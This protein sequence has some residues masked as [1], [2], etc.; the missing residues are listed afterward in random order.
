MNP[1]YDNRVA[2][3]SRVGD[4]WTSVVPQEPRQVVRSLARLVEANSANADLQ[5]AYDRMA[6]ANNNSYAF[7]TLSFLPGAVGVIGGDLNLRLRTQ[8]GDG[9][10]TYV[11]YR[12][13]MN[14]G[15]M[16]EKWLSFMTVN[17][18]ANEVLQ[19]EGEEYI[20]SPAFGEVDVGA[21][22]D[23]MD[24]RTKYV[25]PIPFGVW[26]QVI[27][28]QD[29]YW[30]QGED[31]VTTLGAIITPHDPLLAFPGGRIT[32]QMLQRSSSSWMDYILQVDDMISSGQFVA[33][34]YRGSQ[35]PG[36]FRKAIAEAS[37]LV[38]LPWDGFLQEVATFGRYAYYR[39]DT[40]L[41]VTD[42]PHTAMAANAFYA[43]GTIIG[44]GVKVYSQ[45]Q[46]GGWGWFRQLDWSAGLS[47]DGLTPFDEL[48]VPDQPCRAYATTET[49][50][51]IHARIQISGDQA[52]QDLYWKYVE[53]AENITGNY[54]NSVV[55]LS[56][57]NDVKFVNPLDIY[58]QYFLSKNAIVIELQTA[59]MG[60]YWNK[61]ALS[62]IA[63][64]KPCGSIVILR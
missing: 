11:I 48:K 32:C 2:V 23:L 45:P 4:F 56:S 42:Y 55:G 47:L 25:I 15:A 63:R 3:M 27:L 53:T 6:G 37:G 12:R 16:L 34:Y 40:G 20:L 13:P 60:D 8:W 29:G 1:V 44:D 43:K 9:T 17:K 31:F 58:W 22:I 24:L 7:R 33:Q 5:L 52:T 46:G 39:F 41:L 28:T 14:Y 26:P 38:V 30:I 62:F 36:A 50:G 35:N 51:N 19:T 64:E 61:R 54:L 59:A 21:Q 10:Q 49:D 57:V 18:A